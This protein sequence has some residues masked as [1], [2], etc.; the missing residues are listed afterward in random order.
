MVRV[1][2]NENLPRASVVALRAAGVDVEAVSERMPA[3][4]DRDVLEHAAESGRWLVTF[5]RDYGELVFTRSAPV[6]PAIVFLRQAS[7][8]PA[9][10]A[11]A[12]LAAVA[13]S[14]FV[15]GHLVVAAGS[16][17]RRRSLPLRSGEGRNGPT[18]S[19]C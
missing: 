6:P 17:L 13:R 10:P 8:T 11:E 2:V 12:V 4:N 1:L 3:A 9:W 7:Y 16:T 5:D 19:A 14:D 18:I 15:N